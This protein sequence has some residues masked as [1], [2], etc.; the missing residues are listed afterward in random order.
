MEYHYRFWTNRPG[1]PP[2]GIKSIS[3][4]DGSDKVSTGADVLEQLVERKADIKALWFYVSAT[5]KVMEMIAK[6]P[7]L[8]ALYIHNLVG[9]TNLEQLANLKRLR[10][11]NLHSTS[12]SD[13]DDLN[14]LR[15]LEVLSMSCSEEKLTSLEQLSSLTNLKELILYGRMYESLKMQDL[16]GLEKFTRLQLLDISGIKFE[17]FKVEQFKSLQNLKYLFWHSRLD[18]HIPAIQKL[19]PS[20]EYV[21]RPIA[22]LGLLHVK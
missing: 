6:L 7:D 15:S 5:S 10:F 2:K 19:L 1:F 9:V 4:Y 20:L 13:V 18:E 22:N 21:G 16:T 3:E 12:N 14:Q 8:E 11:L 17:Q